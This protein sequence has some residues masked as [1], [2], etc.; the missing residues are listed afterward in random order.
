MRKHSQLSY[1]DG[2][3]VVFLATGRTP[4]HGILLFLSISREADPRRPTVAAPSA[5]ALGTGPR[6]QGQEP[7]GLC[8]SGG[9]VQHSPRHRAAAQQMCKSVT[10]SSFPAASGVR[11]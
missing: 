10:C 5:P 9:R 3:N 8:G 6:D 2:L 4:A 7:E 1:N 11:D